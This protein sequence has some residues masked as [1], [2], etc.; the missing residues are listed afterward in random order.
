M[1]TYHNLMIGC[2]H[3]YTLVN[4]DWYTAI[5]PLDN[6]RWRCSLTIKTKLL[7]VSYLDKEGQ[8]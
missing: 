3:F 7:K 4:T 5:G 2:F 8:S 6:Q 1:Y